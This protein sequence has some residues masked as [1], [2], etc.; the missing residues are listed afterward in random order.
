MTIFESL[1]VAHILGDWLLQTEWQATNKEQ[2]WSALIIHVGIYHLIVFVILYLGFGLSLEI[3]VPVV[4]VLALLHGLL[5]RRSFVLWL[6]RSLRITVK[7]KPEGLLLL[8][9]DQSAHLVLLAL[10]AVVL[11]NL[12]SR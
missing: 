7:R 12:A 5:D 1:V 9:V 4:A 3:I 6:M 11:T 10:A 2:N 8:A